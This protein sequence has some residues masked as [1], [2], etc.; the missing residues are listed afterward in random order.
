MKR[1]VIAILSDFGYS[2]GALATMKAVILSINPDVQ[3]VDISHDI[4]PYDIREGAFV[5]YRCHS[6]FPDG[7]IFL[8][9]VDPGV[10]SSRLPIILSTERF[11]YVAPDNGLLSHVLPQSGHSRIYHL[12]DPA[13][14]LDRMSFTF[15]GRDLFAPAAAYLSLGTAVHQFGQ[16][17][18]DM[19]C[20]KSSPPRIVSRD[21]I[22]TEVLFADSYGNAYSN[23]D[24][25]RF[26][27]VLT[28]GFYEI[29]IGG[30]S[31]EG[32]FKKSNCYD[33]VEKGKELIYFG[34]SG[35]LELALREGSFM[36]SFPIKPGDR[37]IISKVL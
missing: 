22:E 7:T 26:K 19:V 6:Y 12:S 28:E 8:C 34:S 27:D 36:R 25:E 4:T 14:R 33:D 29:I 5:L 23:I 32:L 10:G 24:E 30:R 9:V 20:F 16:E 21:S 3:L 35:F 11:T 31:L 17:L 37:F 13:Y 15:H 1:P 2:D 18:K